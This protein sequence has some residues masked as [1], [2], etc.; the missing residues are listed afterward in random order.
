VKQV[1][2]TLDLYE[3]TLDARYRIILRLTPDEVRFLRFGVY[4]PSK[5]PGH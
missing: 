2:G 5:Q 1:S 3:L 4:L